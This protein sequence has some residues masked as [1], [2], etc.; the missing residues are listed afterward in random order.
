MTPSPLAATQPH[1]LRRAF[2]AVIAGARRRN[3]HRSVRPAHGPDSADSDRNR[4]AMSYRPEVDGLRAIA[5]I[6]VVLFHARFPGFAGGF[7]GVDVFFVISGY[8]ITS[9]IVR[10]T[11]LGTFSYAKFYERRARRILPALNTVAIVSTIAAWFVLVPDAYRDFSESIIAVVGFFANILF[12]QKSGYFEAAAELKPMLHTWSLSIEEQYYLLFPAAVLL[13]WRLR[14]EWFAPALAMGALGSFVVSVWTTG[15]HPTAAF[16]SLPTRAWELLLGALTALAATSSR[17][18][19]V[20]AER[21][22]GAARAGWG[23]YVGLTLIAISIV[24]FDDATPFPGLAALLPTLGAAAVLYFAIP[25]THSARL[26]S[27]RPLVGIGLMSYSVYLWHQPMLALLQHANLD[28]PSLLARALAV[29]GVFPLAALSYRFIERPF[30]NAR[31]VSRRALVA[32][33]GASSAVLLLSGIAGRASGGFPTRFRMPATVA[34]TFEM[35]S[36]GASCF[37]RDL[38]HVREDWLCRFG[39]VAGRDTIFLLGDSHGLALLPAFDRAAKL[40]DTQ[41]L[42]TGA[43]GCPPLLGIHALRADQGARNC[44]LLNR[45]VYDFVRA[46]GIHKVYLVGRWTY[47][48]D[49]GY[50]GDNF[51]YIGLTPTTA[52]SPDRSREAFRVGLRHTLE[53]YDSIG[54][55]VVV[56]SQVPQQRKDPLGVYYRAFQMSEARRDSFLNEASVLREDHLRLNRMVDVILSSPELSRPHLQIMSVDSILCGA[57]RCPIGTSAG[58]FYRDDDHLS[59]AGSLRL[60]PLLARSLAGGRR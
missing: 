14:R 15:H 50:H 5:V 53:A 48:T 37:D 31:V 10:E 21:T 55:P 46:H 26:L 56:M 7:V 25:G 2:T 27:V 29:S 12:W 38:V 45:R 32:W 23:G 28:R 19:P 33:V 1:V 8:L 18:L 4:A 22:E 11:Q 41:V 58:S 40:S 47:Y 13:V 30:R 16:F 52:Q 9:I 43:S 59:V 42:F 35:D 24:V 39:A 34:A 49:G 57:K 44:H 54:V 3:G 6:P 17:C 20:D 51:S 36:A 60:V